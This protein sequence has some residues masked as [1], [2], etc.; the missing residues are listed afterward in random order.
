MKVL[1]LLLGWL[2]AAMSYSI[3]TFDPYSAN[4]AYV[5]SI[6]AQ[7][8]P[9]ELEMNKFS[10]LSSRTFDTDWKGYRPSYDNPVLQ[11]HLTDSKSYLDKVDWRSTP[12]VGKVKDQKQCGSCWAFSAVA[13]LEGQVAKRVNKSVSL[14][15]QDMVDCVKN[16]PS[17]DG[18]SVCCDGCGG[19]EMYSVYQYLAKHQHGKDDMEDQYKYT[20]TDGICSPVKSQSPGTGVKSFVTIKKGDEKAM[21]DALARVGP[22]SVG[23]DANTDWQLYKKGIYAPNSTQ[24]SSDPMDQDHG[25]AV[26]GYGSSILC[27]VSSCANLD[28]W[29]IRNSWGESWGE[30]GYMRLLRGKNACGVANSAIYPI[31]H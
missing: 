30:K 5:N 9:W 2:A 29:I 3:G 26:V 25:V 7:S 4:L 28:Y 17:P 12:L 22:L 6:N 15:E 16:I 10:H 1:I 18:T 13:S 31:L 24:C 11:Q 19:G 8:L 21:M 20:A 27:N 23:V 14:S